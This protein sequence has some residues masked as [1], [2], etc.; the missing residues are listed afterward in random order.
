M[1]RAKPVADVVGTDPAAAL[2]GWIEQQRDLLDAALGGWLQQQ[3][4]FNKA[5]FDW[6]D[7]LYG[8]QAGVRDAAWPAVGWPTLPEELLMAGPRLLQVWWAP[9][10]PFVER[11]GEQLG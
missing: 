3:Q 4:A 10:A 6:L 7:A 1:A 2:D 9:W 11:G 5:W 8:S